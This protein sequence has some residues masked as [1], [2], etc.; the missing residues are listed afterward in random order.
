MHGE[1]ADKPRY[2]FNFRVGV[3]EKKRKGRK[4]REGREGKKWKRKAHKKGKCSTERG[5][6]SLLGADERTLIAAL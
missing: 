1:A 3:G 5:G 4:G 2:S 6:G